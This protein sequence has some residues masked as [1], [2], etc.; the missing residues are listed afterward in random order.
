MTATARPATRETERGFTL[1][2]VLAALAIASV[3]IIATAGLMHDV[4]LNFDRGTRGVNSAEH[5]L[6]AVERLAA[7]FASA[8]PVP[9]LGGGGANA[10]VAFVGEPTRVKLVAAG[11][12]AA[13]GPQ[14]EELVSL[15]VEEKDGASRLIRRRAAWLG[16]RTPFESVALR[17]PVS[18]I[19]G[20]IDIAFA[21]GRVAPDG[22]M[23]WTDTW[24]AQP[25]LPRLVRLTV[26]DRASG[27]ELI[28]GTQFVLRADAPISCAAPEANAACL[29][30]GKPPSTP[31]KTAQAEGRG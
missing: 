4:V 10:T 8:R 31:A 24:S 12:G 3:V 18:L 20:K 7:D 30:G 19:D 5:L 9:Q 2:E 22:A 6:L 29:S 13:A 16:P 27:V 21:F 1:I 23:I 11:G 17:D 15:T 25:L 14:G 26:R 28:P